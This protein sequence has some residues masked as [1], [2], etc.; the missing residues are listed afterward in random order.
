[1]L[2]ADL[3]PPVP[4]PVPRTILYQR[5][6][7]NRRILNEEMFLKVLAEYG[8]VR[9]LPVYLQCPNPPSHCCVRM[10]AHSAASS[11]ILAQNVQV[12][13]HCTRT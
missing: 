4:A 5:K 11:C 3:T 7:A 13:F 9:P 6:R 2:D 1:M 10:W 12:A 8:Q